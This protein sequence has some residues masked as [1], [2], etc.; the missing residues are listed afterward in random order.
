MVYVNVVLQL[1]TLLLLDLWFTTCLVIFSP[2]Y[3]IF[4]S[5][6]DEEDE[7]NVNDQD[8]HRLVIVT[9]VRSLFFCHISSIFKAV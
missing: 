1:L 3:A 4:N 7:V 8:V 6:D 5:V 9:Q 2:N